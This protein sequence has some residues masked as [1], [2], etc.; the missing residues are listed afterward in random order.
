MAGH[1]REPGPS[2]V[3]VAANLRRIRQERGLSYAEL[4]R[5]LAAVGHPILDTGLIK[6]EKGERRVD[7]DDLVALAVALGTTPNRLLLP[8]TDIADG[9]IDHALVP[10]IRDSRRGLWAWA[11]GEV[12]LGH[13]SASAQTSSDLRSEEVSFNRENRPHHWNLFIRDKEIPG[14]LAG[15]QRATAGQVAQGDTVTGLIALVVETFRDNVSTAGIRTVVE[16]GLTGALLSP[17][18]MDLSVTATR[19]EGRIRIE[20]KADGSERQGS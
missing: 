11:S 5:R 1:A 13:K 10:E 16:A 9:A 20:I 6:V 15:I 4:A 17:D 2:S 12:P 7:V 3:R 14:L 19:N 8:G 18:A